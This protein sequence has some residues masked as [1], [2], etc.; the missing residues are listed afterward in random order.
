[1]LGWL[2][3]KVPQDDGRYGRTDTY[4]VGRPRP[5]SR[6]RVP[7]STVNARGSTQVTSVPE[8]G[9]PHARSEGRVSVA[10]LSGGSYETNVVLTFQPSIF[11]AGVPSF[12]AS[13][14][15]LHRIELDRASWLD[16]VPGWVSG[17]DRLFAEVMAT[18]PWG[19]R[20]RRMYDRRVREPRLTSSWSLTSGLP[21][22]PPILEEIRRCLGARYGVVFDSAGFN[23][24]RNGA[25]SVA[26]HGDKIRKEIEEP[27]IPLLS[28]GEPRKFA[29][30]PQGGGVSRAFCL[31]RG[32][33]LVTGGATHRAWQHAVP[34]VAQAGPRISVAYRYGMDIRAY[35]TLEAT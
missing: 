24:Y 8:A 33:L 1:V 30:R 3:A 12:D 32:D 29:L 25:D 34:K 27:I 28:L 19:E 26:W 18:R 11:A 6:A 10:A 2:S 5:G 22:E 9:Q 15:E 17:S 21:L 14:R 35:A 7:S 13:F 23:L 31:G 4:W 20:T 16:L